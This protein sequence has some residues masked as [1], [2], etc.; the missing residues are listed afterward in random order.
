MAAES[1]QFSGN[2][3]TQCTI[4]VFFN[5]L[6]R[7]LCVCVCVL[8]HLVQVPFAKYYSQ[9]SNTSSG[10]SSHGRSWARCYLIWS[11]PEVNCFLLDLCGKWPEPK[12][13]NIFVMVVWLDGHYFV[14]RQHKKHP[15]HGHTLSCRAESIGELFF[16]RGSLLAGPDHRHQQ[17]EAIRMLLIEKKKIKCFYSAAGRHSAF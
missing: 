11:F 1:N 9:M 3:K 6:C 14:R 7:G 2:S 4:V 10:S 5:V 15:S 16:P 17:R 12:I 8:L 13:V